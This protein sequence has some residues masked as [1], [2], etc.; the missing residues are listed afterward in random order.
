M[1]PVHGPAYPPNVRLAWAYAAGEDAVSP[2]STGLDRSFK[3]G[4]GV[5]GR[6]VAHA[7]AFRT[8][9]Y[10][11]DGRFEHNEVSDELVRITGFNSVLSAP[12]RGE[13]GPLGALTVSSRRVEA[14]D[15]A[16]AGLLQALADQAAIAIQN[17]RLIA[18]P[19][20]SRSE[21]TRRADAQQALR[22]IG[23]RITAIR[24]P[25]PL[26][27]QVVDAARRL[28]G[29][30]G[31]ILDLVN[32]DANEVRWTYD[33]GVRAGF[34]SEEIA[35]LTIPIGVGATGIA[36]AEGRV[37]AASDD[38]RVHFPPSQINDRFFGM[39][40]YRSMIIAPITGESGPLGALEVYSKRP[41]AFDDEDAAVIRT[42]AYQAAIAITNTHLIQE[43]ERSQATVEARAERERS[44][45]DIT[46]RIT[47]LRD[48]EEIL[49]RVVEEARRLLRSD[50]AHLTRMSEE[51][52]YLVP[53]FV[54]GGLDPG[55][56]EWLKQM[57]FPLGGGINGLAAEEA[58]PI[59]TGNYPEDP[60]IPHEWDD[61][62][63][64]ARLGLGAMAAAPLRAPAGEVIGTL[65]ISYRNPR[66]IVPDE[67]DLLQG[68]ADQ[69]A[70]A[71][72]NS[73]LY[74]LLGESEARYRHLVQNS[75][76]L[77]WSIDQDA[78]FTFVSDCE[79]LTGWRPE[80]LLGK[81]FGALVHESSRAVAELDW[82]ADLTAEFQ[83]LRGRLNVLPADVG[84]PLI[85]PGGRSIHRSGAR[86]ASLRLL[87]IDERHIRPRRTYSARTLPRRSQPTSM[88][89]YSTSP[90]GVRT[91]TVSP[92]LRPMR[93]RP[94][95]D[96]FEIRPAAGSASAV[97]TSS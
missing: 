6:V 35:Q 67:L 85:T 62:E 88:I 36:V 50:S 33:S 23:A 2:H 84:S 12:L 37:I 60:R 29:G 89:R 91:A 69:A 3:V 86:R 28:V 78:R 1:P 49:A 79:R 68:L 53:V 41:G 97:P 56:E 57:K 94:T 95:G 63:V 47:S 90:R 58:E 27:Q 19:N 46:G 34:S 44:L 17:A 21:L 55:T 70:I 16:Q 31:S 82:T 42:L 43:L 71:L 93:A 9:D 52:T 87:N 77:I 64:A 92:T 59:W 40:G 51:G 96:A 30:D 76:D 74:E 22:E 11:A 4:E 14:Y 18:E 24:E 75:P 25:G 45:R 32:P 83:E 38:L 65:A 10:L 73:N 5:A 20:R 81:H 39:T 61:D 7:E 66:E 54:A 8:G 26:L 15:D 48:P 13:A 80:D 72:T